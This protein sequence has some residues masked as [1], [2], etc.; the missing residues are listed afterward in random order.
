MVVISWVRLTSWVGGLVE[1]EQRPN[2]QTPDN[3]DATTISKPT[4]HEFQNKL[5]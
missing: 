1:L 4:K 5:T 2:A 3:S